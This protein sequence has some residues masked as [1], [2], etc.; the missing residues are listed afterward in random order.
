[1]TSKV[2]QREERQARLFQPGRAP[3][4]GQ[5]DNGRA[6]GDG[7]AQLLQ[8]AAPGHHGAAGGDQVVDLP[9]LG[10]SQ[11]LRDSGLP[12]FTLVDFAGH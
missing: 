7:G 3:Q 8:Q 6:L 12:L 10:G 4:L 2:H 5:I 1:M 9:E 11:K